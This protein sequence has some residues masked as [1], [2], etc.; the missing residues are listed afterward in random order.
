[1]LAETGQHA[2]DFIKGGPQCKIIAFVY[3]AQ[4]ISYQ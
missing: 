4:S 2:F 1:V 3:I